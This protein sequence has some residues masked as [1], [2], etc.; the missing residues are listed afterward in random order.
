M[1]ED[2]PMVVSFV[3]S[4]NAASSEEL[5]EFAD[6]L[7]GRVVDGQGNLPDQEMALA[8]YRRLGSA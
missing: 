5:R 1:S 4:L 3:E 8:L 7:M 2:D 6:L